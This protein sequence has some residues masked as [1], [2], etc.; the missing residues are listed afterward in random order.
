[1]QR[2]S[3]PFSFLITIVFASRLFSQ[4]ETGDFDGDGRLSIRD[5]AWYG[6]GRALAPGSDDA[7]RDH[8]CSVAPWWQT[9]NIPAIVYQEV[10]RRRVEGSLPNWENV[11]F[12]PTDI[13]GDPFPPDGRVLIRIDPE[14]A[15]GGENDRVM[16]RIE[17]VAFRESCGVALS[18]RSRFVVA[19]HFDADEVMDLA[20]TLPDE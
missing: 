8:F 14:A 2:K 1:M 9:L 12:W 6:D 11:D 18:S 13:Q 4:V 16:L 15:S 7:F 5:V 19:G 20:A 10:L 3:S 17:L